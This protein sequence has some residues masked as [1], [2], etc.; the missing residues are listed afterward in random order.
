MSHPDR[1]TAH[2]TRRDIGCEPSSLL[3]PLDP[4]KAPVYAGD[5]GPGT[6]VVEVPA[7]VVPVTVPLNAIAVLA[8]FLPPHAYVTPVRTAR[9]SVEDPPACAWI[10]SASRSRPAG[11]WSVVGF[12][13]NNRRHA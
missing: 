9:P 11:R 6:W 4:T 10:A 1:A 7:G 2:T 13:F 8:G 3:V 5:L 12:R